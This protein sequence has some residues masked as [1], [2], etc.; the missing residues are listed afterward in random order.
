MA[1]RSSALSLQSPLFYF[2]FLL[3]R[4]LLLLLL[5][6]L[7]LMVVLANCKIVTYPLVGLASIVTTSSDVCRCLTEYRIVYSTHVSIR[8]VERY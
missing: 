8:I 1:S 6:L 3:L 7:L 2:S 4:F 5:L